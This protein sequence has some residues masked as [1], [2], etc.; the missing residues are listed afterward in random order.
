MKSWNLSLLVAPWLCC[1]CLNVPM[2][3]PAPPPLPAPATESPRT[4]KAEQVTQEN[5]PQ[6]LEAI[7]QELDRAESELP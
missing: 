3:P 5:A 7:R 6:M 2:A 4:V 1:G